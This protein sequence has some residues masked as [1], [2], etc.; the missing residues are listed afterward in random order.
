MNFR[1]VLHAIFCLLFLT[2]FLAGF[3]VHAAEPL[4]LSKTGSLKITVHDGATPVPGGQLTLYRV[5]DIDV[6]GATPKFVLNAQVAASKISLSDVHSKTT[7][8]NLLQWMQNHGIQGQVRNVG[9]DGT[10]IYTDVPAG[11]YLVTQNQ[12]AT[13]YEAMAPFLISVPNSD[14]KGGYLYDVSAY[15]KSDPAKLPTQ[16]VPKQPDIPDNPG[17]PVNPPTPT[18]P[19]TPAAPTPPVTQV[20]VYKEV[21]VYSYTGVYDSYV[22]DQSWKADVPHTSAAAASWM[23]FAGAAILAGLAWLLM[24]GYRKR[25]RTGASK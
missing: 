10:V 4:D 5:G 2:G 11:L 25:S 12:A 21:P 19:V 17:T 22:Q 24:S 16:D 20:P 13:G 6:S 18:T 7:A 1:K 9:S 8:Q 14:G 15:P 3:P 23:Q